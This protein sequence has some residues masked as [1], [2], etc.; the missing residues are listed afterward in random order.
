MKRFRYE[1]G[2]RP[3]H[4]VGIV[5]S[6]AV[7]AYAGYKIFQRPDRSQI[8][9]WFLGAILL[10]DLVFLPLY[11]ALDRLPARAARRRPTPLLALNHVRIPLAISGLLFILFIPLILRTG[12]ATYT[13]VSGQTP[14]SYLERWLGITA[15]LFVGSALLLVVRRVR[16]SRSGTKD[17]E[18][19]SVGPA[20]PAAN[21]RAVGVARAGEPTPA[22]GPPRARE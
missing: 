20:E 11:S 10:H 16:A 1:Y 19:S 22:D 4:L 15:V 6:L 13:S 18:A 5:L 8:A 3:L 9:I 12:E 17:S 2:A 14:D 21:G 7:A